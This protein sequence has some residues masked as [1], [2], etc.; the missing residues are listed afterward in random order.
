MFET[1]NEEHN[2]VQ[3]K[4]HHSRQQLEADEVFLI[5]QCVVIC[6]IFCC[7]SLNLFEDYYVPYKLE[8]P[9]WGIVQKFRSH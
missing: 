6:N 2:I 4:L 5:R 7:L 9:K 1:V 3:F 8:M